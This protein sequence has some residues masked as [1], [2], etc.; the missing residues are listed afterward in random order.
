M[1]IKQLGL[2]WQTRRTRSSK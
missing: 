2:C 1:S